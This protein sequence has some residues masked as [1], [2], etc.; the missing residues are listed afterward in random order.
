MTPEPFPNSVEVARDHNGRVLIDPVEGGF[1]VRHEC[2][3]PCFVERPSGKASVMPEDQARR[4]GQMWVE[5]GGR[6]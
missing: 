2:F 6:L 5:H 3:G 4:W 1:T